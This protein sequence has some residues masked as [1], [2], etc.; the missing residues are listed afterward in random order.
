MAKDLE[1]ERKELYDKITEAR[2]YMERLLVS[3]CRLSAFNLLSVLR[4]YGMVIGN[5]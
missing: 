1:R 4:M 2:E 5:K 3:D